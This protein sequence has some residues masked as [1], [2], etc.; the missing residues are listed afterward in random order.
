MPALLLVAGCC[1]LLNALHATPDL[2]SSSRQLLCAILPH[3]PRDEAT[4]DVLIMRI[5]RRTATGEEVVGQRR[6][7]L[8]NVEVDRD[9]RPP[10]EHGNGFQPYP[11]PE[12][13]ATT[14]TVVACLH[15]M[16]WTREF[17]H[18]LLHSVPQM[19][20]S[21]DGY[22]D[23]KSFE[24][25]WGARFADYALRAVSIGSFKIH[26]NRTRTKV[27]QPTYVPTPQ[28]EHELL[29][30][31]GERGRAYIQ[32][33]ANPFG[34]D[35]LENETWNE[36][37]TRIYRQWISDIIRM[38]PNQRG[39]Q[40]PTHSKLSVTA[41]EQPTEA[42][43]LVDN[44]ALIVRKAHWRIRDAKQLKIVTD[45]LFPKVPTPRP[46]DQNYK[47][48]RYYFMWN[49]FLANNTATI[50]LRAQELIAARLSTLRWLPLV[51][52]DRI[53]LTGRK[54]FPGKQSSPNIGTNDIAPSL[55]CVAPVWEEPAVS[56]YTSS[57]QHM[58]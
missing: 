36:R 2:G 5:G 21:P 34:I 50:G 20:P 27:V 39:Q 6:R 8:Y 42:L 54:H 24:Y 4:D 12:F 48:A 33:S 26:K 10:I 9:D 45:R 15:G 38:M 18:D 23:A 1:W 46:R 47:N 53:W 56:R 22:I 44:I 16:I 31:L 37:L 13:G 14:D 51:P 29:F 7:F 43:F 40:N 35:T 41:R 32:P 25:L 11:E 3:I 49:H 55:L 58:N 28:E 30:D 17:L 52:S 57:H 19:A